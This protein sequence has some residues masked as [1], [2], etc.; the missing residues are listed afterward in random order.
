M[1]LFKRYNDFWWEVKSS[2]MKMGA[3]D[4]NRIISASVTEEMGNMDSCVITMLDPNAIYSRT[5]RPGMK[6]TFNWGSQIDKRGAIP[7]LVNSP[8]GSAGSDGKIIFNMRGQALG[9]N[10]EERIY[11]NIGTKMTVVQ[12]VLLK[13]GIVDAEVDFARGT[14][15]VNNDNKIS[16]HESNFRFLSRMAD[17]WRCVFRVG[18]TKAGTKCAVFC[19][20]SK[21]ATKMFMRKIVLTSAHLEYGT[22]FANVIEYSWQDQ[23]LDA[24]M[25]AG[26]NVI[27]VNGEPQFKRYIAKDEMVVTYRLDMNKVLAEFNSQEDFLKKT[28]VTANVMSARSFKEV[29]RFFVE[30][31]ITT[32]PQGSGIT[33]SVRMFGD[34]N[35][36]AGQV[37]TFGGGFPDRIGA[38][39]RTWYIKNC[40]HEMSSSGYFVNL[41][42]VDA[43]VLIAAGQSV[44]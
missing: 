19:E 5:F 39:G 30:D 9:D 14:E 41:E 28:Q 36:T 8:S 23:S 4:D 43:F 22:G 17:E 13:M 10:E 34:I 7:F 44:R 29:E 24:A 35:I 16:Q 15:I 27:Y 42:V 1:T 18:V 38:K 6:F 26:V 32:A 21:L 33:V 20:P 31:T 2:D 40:T 12:E 25:G 3:V 37:V 11:Y